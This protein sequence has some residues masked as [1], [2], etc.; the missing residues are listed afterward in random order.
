MLFCVR[1]PFWTGV[2][3]DG[4]VVV[5][6]PHPGPTVHSYGCTALHCAARY[7]NRRIVRLL[8]ASGADVNAQNDSK[9]AVPACGESAECAGRV[10][11]AVCHAGA[12]RCTLPRSMAIPN[13]SRSCCSAAPTGPSR[14]TSSG[15]AALRR[16]AE[17]ETVTAARVQEHAEARSGTPWDARGVRGG[18]EASNCPPPHIPPPSPASRPIPPR[19]SFTD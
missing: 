15:T 7:G 9:C 16:T 2:P 4:G 6:T 5:P 3:P 14:A 13:P 12:R 10:P 8:V 18:R 19:A 1:V 17:T 11:T